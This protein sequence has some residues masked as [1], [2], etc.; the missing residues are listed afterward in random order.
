MTEQQDIRRKLNK[1]WGFGAKQSSKIGNRNRKFSKIFLSWTLVEVVPSEPRQ[2]HVRSRSDS[3]GTSDS[4][5]NHVRFIFLICLLFLL[6]LLS[7][8]YQKFQHTLC[9]YLVLSKILY[10]KLL[11][12]SFFTYRIY[13]YVFLFIYSFFTRFSLFSNFIFRKNFLRIYILTKF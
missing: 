7:K 6:C 5:Q 9:Y 12:S 10:E 3:C 13:E 4:R 11:L 1:I 2:K 8:S